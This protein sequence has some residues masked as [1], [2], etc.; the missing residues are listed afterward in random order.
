MAIHFSVRS[1]FY[2][3]SV[4]L[5]AVARELR[6]LEGVH[7]AALVM[8][9]EANKELLGQMTELNEAAQSAQPVDLIV[10]IDAPEA[11]L[12][13]AI[14]KMD[15]LLSAKPSGG[16]DPQ[17][18][19][20]R[21]LRSARRMQP[22]TQLAVISV[23]GEYAAAEAWKALYS[24]LHVFLFSDNVP[25]QDERAL[26]T[27]AAQN[28]LFVMG[29][30][31]G[32]AFLSGTGLGFAN[33]VPRGK[34]GIVSASGTGL[35]EVSTLLAKQGTGISQAIGVGGRDLSDEIDGIMTVQ[36]VEFLQ[37]ERDTDVIVAISKLPSR[38][39][40]SAVIEQLAAGRKPAVVI[41]MSRELSTAPEGV[42]VT[43]TLHEAA[44]IA[45]ALATGGDVGQARQQYTQQLAALALSAAEWRANLPEQRLY[46]RGLFGG[47]TLCEEAIGIWSGCVGD[48]WSNAPLNPA[49]QLKDSQHSQAHSAIDLG[50]EEFTV[51]RPH[52]MIDNELR[53][54]R[55]LKEAADPLVAA[56]QMDVVIGY[57]A[58]PD[59]AD[60]LAP[61]IARAAEHL[62]VIVSITGTDD[63]R[64]NL[65][66]QRTLFEA[67]GAVVLESNALASQFA[68]HLAGGQR[69]TA[70]LS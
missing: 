48:V 31:A 55:L 53:I 46:L 40:A 7:D 59:P 28:G 39:I 62:P 41:F 16:N 18:P 20:P 3:D 13:L 24:G 25:L 1:G 36:A 32:T 14:E 11:M 19:T 64:Q 57:G 33:V 23:P 37:Q 6:R 49:Y 42:Y 56:I 67:A 60:D 29:P 4:L 2:A 38:R 35:Q 26:K 50:D 9:T 10:M 30:G 34:V 69:D 51:G 45:H 61:A 58:H 17:A 43:S 22:D 44:V 65:A 54:Q 68:A 47:G 8:G 27:Y 63:D 52:P 15:S 70:R 66:R 5:M 12:P 21:S